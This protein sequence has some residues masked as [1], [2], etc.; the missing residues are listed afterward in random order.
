LELSYPDSELRWSSLT[1]LYLRGMGIALQRG[2]TLEL[3]QF[4]L[5]KYLLLGEIQG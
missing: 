4:A 2:A 1:V 5:Q 3:E